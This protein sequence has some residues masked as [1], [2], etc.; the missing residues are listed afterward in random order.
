VVVP[1]KG[2]LV[3]DGTNQVHL[4]LDC[5]TGVSVESD[6]GYYQLGNADIEELTEDHEGQIIIQNRE[7]TT[8]YVRFLQG[9]PRNEVN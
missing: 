7:N 2:Q 1:A 6:K 3:L 9:V 8:R 5:G 4:I